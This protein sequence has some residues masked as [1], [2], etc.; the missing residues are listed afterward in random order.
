M[1]PRPTEVGTVVAKPKKHK[2]NYK[3][4][5]RELE[6]LINCYSMENGSNTPDWVLAEYLVNCLKNFDTTSRAREKWYGKELT[7]GED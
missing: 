4:F 6:T 1:K 5:Q 3:K 2:I 7:I